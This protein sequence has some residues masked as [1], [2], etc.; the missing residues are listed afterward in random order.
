MSNRHNPIARTIEKLQ[1]KWSEA[2]NEKPD[3]KLIRWM[4]KPDNSPLINGFYKIESSRFGSLPEFFLVQF[5]AFDNS[6][7][8]PKQLVTDWIDIWE[9][10]PSVKEANAIWDT[11]AIRNKVSAV[12]T[13]KEADQLFIDT[14]SDFRNRFCRDN[15]DLV[16]TMIP[17]SV[18]DFSAFNYWLI[19]MVEKLP[20]KI[21]ISLVD[22]V[23]E[24][25]LKSTF[26][27][28]PKETI[29]I[30]SEDIDINNLAK[31]MATSGDPNNPEIEFRKCVFEMADGLIAKDPR[32]IITWGQKAIAVAQK[33]GVASMVGTAYLIYAGFMLQLR[34][35]AA[36][37]LLDI[38]ISISENAYKSGDNNASYVL[39]QL[40]G[41][42]AAFQRIQGKRAESCHWLLKQ[43][44]M[45]TSINLPIL[46]ISQY[47]VLARI[48]KQAWDNEIY[49]T[50]LK[51]GYEASETLTE[52]ELKVSE[53]KILAFNYVKELKDYEKYDKAE[54][55][56]ARMVDLFGKNWTKDIPG[57][58]AKYGETIPRIEDTIES[59]N[60]K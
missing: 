58:R 55:V 28:F 4:I 19:F 43:A 9:S 12:K 14:L 27:E 54:E 33:T 13:Q 40:Y 7:D 2:T 46:A 32:H 20:E 16:F 8:F 42:K 38:G 34:K 25:Y 22:H 57:I 53:I 56:E 1:S 31:E 35:N 11:A 44:R 3:Y 21:K 45:A 18:S 50:S 51:E 26:K 37:N 52:E 5:T 24:N 47:R 10:D 15:Q 41:Y 17:K 60:L 39:M 30:K 59:L 23:G 6:L 36:D 49:Y 29:T 48:A